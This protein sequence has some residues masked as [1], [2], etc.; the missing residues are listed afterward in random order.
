MRQVLLAEK[1]VTPLQCLQQGMVVVED[2]MISALGRREELQIPR[3]AKV[4]DFGT[5]VLAPGLVDLHVHGGGGV[6]FMQAGLARDLRGLDAIRSHLARYGT[7]TALAT[8]VTA[9]WDDTLKAIHELSMAGWDIHA[10]GPFLSERQRGVHPPNLL[11]EPSSERLEQMWESSEGRLR[12]ITLAPELTGAG[13]F[14]AAAMRHGITIAIGHS[15]ATLEQALAGI[16]AGARHV[17]HTFNA[18]PALHHRDPGLLGAVLSQGDV[19]AEII[20]DGIHVHP[21][22]VNLFL[23]LKGE[24]SAI[25]VSDGI[26]ATGCGD[27]EFMLGG[28]TVE[29]KDGRCLLGNSL[30]GSVLTLDRAVSNVVH[31]SGWPVE[32]ALRLA[33]LNPANALGW[34]AK[35]RVEVGADADLVVL[36]PQGGVV[37][38]YVAGQQVN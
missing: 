17:T 36:T 28:L 7:T 14:I 32:R 29:V 18:M 9:K 10:E 23:K 31:W 1:V 21:V 4:T 35:G 3:A 26:S 5:A 30:A 33:T 6:D 2:G 16:A 11:L 27:G 15:N 37:A 13:E 25:L 24:A 8:T 20:A 22:V 12:W 19:T 34:K 38:T